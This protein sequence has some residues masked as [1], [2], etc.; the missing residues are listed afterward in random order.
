MVACGVILIVWGI[1][2]SFAFPLSNA[3]GIGIVGGIACLVAHARFRRIEIVLKI[4]KEV[5]DTGKIKL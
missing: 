3:G 2:G 5:P 4:T 1:I